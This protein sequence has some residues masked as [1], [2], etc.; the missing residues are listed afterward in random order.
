MD[1]IIWHTFET[2]VTKVNT[3]LNLCAAEKILNSRT[4]YIEIL[5]VNLKYI[6]KLNAKKTHGH[7]SSLYGLFFFNLL[8]NFD[9]EFTPHCHFHPTQTIR[10]ENIRDHIPQNCNDFFLQVDS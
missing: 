5:C 1:F 9:V 4:Y 8:N 3:F 2:R 6:Q 10:D 7:E